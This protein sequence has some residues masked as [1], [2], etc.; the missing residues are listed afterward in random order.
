MLAGVLFIVVVMGSH[1]PG[2][3]NATAANPVL[4]AAVHGLMITAALLMW[5]PVC[6]PL[7]ELRIT[8][9]GAMIYLFLQSVVPTVP[10]AW[11]TFAEG[12]VYSRYDVPERVWGISVTTDQQIAGAVLKAGGGVFLWIVVIVMF[13]R[14]FARN[15]GSDQSFR[16]LS[17]VQPRLPVDER[18]ELT[19]ERITKAFEA[20]PAA[21]HPHDV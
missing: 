15:F 19:Y 1:V 14:H 18:G 21:P 5:M 4:H 10:A 2:V 13:F 12:V 3:V 9:A 8:R 6:G 11:L 20:V 7:P 16:K 17:D